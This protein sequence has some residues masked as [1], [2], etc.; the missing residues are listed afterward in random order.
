MGGSK[1][2]CGLLHAVPLLLAHECSA[3]SLQRAT[4]SWSRRPAGDG[5]CDLKQMSPPACGLGEPAA[6]Y[7]TSDFLLRVAHGARCRPDER[8]AR[9]RTVHCVL[10]TVGPSFQ[11]RVGLIEQALDGP[12]VP[13]RSLPSSPRLPAAERLSPPL[14]HAAALQHVRALGS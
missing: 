12:R 4:V 8:H 14:H 11:G 3:C 2:V 1:I 10:Y 5:A 13:P 6:I 7:M 9:M